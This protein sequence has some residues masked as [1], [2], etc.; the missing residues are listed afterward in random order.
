MDGHF[1]PAGIEGRISAKDVDFVAIAVNRTIRVV[2]PT[3]NLPSGERY[4]QAIVPES[5]FVNGS[6]QIR[7]FAVVQRVEKKLSCGRPCTTREP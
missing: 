1:I 7:A 5:S 6:N 2:A 3:F 4:F